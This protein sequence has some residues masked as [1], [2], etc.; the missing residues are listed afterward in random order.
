MA[1]SKSRSKME[2]TKSDSETIERWQAGTKMQTDDE[3]EIDVLNYDDEDANEIERLLRGAIQ[4]YGKHNEYS[5]PLQSKTSSRLESS[6]LLYNEYNVETLEEKGGSGDTR[7]VGDLI[8]SNIKPNLACAISA[9]KGDHYDILSIF[10]ATWLKSDYNPAKHRKTPMTAAI[11]GGHLKF[12]ELLL[13]QNDF[14]STRR[15]RGQN[16]L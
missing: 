16:L 14:D 8:N 11:D 6:R 4:Y 2:V 1:S 9:A 12:V 15:D 5:E 7:A 13:E 10:L 3:T